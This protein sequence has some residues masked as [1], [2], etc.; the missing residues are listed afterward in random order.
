MSF[1]RRE[2]FQIPD[3]FMLVPALQPLHSLIVC[4]EHAPICIAEEVASDSFSLNEVQVRLPGLIGL[5][6]FQLQQFSKYH[7][8]LARHRQYPQQACQV[9][10]VHIVSL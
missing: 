5:S 4:Q 1:L 7:T 10:D 2:S 9:V 6:L 3:K 8:T